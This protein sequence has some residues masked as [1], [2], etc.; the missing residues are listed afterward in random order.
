M[1]CRT[2]TRY[3]LMCALW[4][5]VSFG[6]AAQSAP[7]LTPPDFTRGERVTGENNTWALGP[8]GA[9][10]EIWAMKNAWNTVGATQI[11]VTQVDADTP[12][13]GVLSVGDV[14]L[15][16]VSPAV[17]D[18][19][20][21]AAARFVVDARK[22]LAAAITAAE[23]AKRAGRLV[24]N[25]WRDG[26]TRKAEL[27][28]RVMGSFSEASPWECEKSE[29]I[30]KRACDF[31]VKQGFEGRGGIPT[32]LDALGLLATGDTQYLPLVKQYAR[33]IGSP[34]VSLD[35]NQ[36]MV[37]WNW[38][39]TLLFLSEY[40]GVTQDDYVLPA[41]REYAITIAKGQSGAGTWGHS[42]AR[43]VENDGKLHGPCGGYGSMNQIG[44][45]C[46]LALVLAQKCGVDHPEIDQALKRSTDFMRFYVD[47][48]SLPY[49]DTDPWGE[50]D[51]NG[52]NSQ[53]AV[54][55]DLMGDGEAARYFAKMTLASYGIRERGHT[56]H[57]FSF[58][59]GAPGAARAGN[60]AAA[61]F[62]REMRWFYELERRPAGNFRYQR[63]L[64]NA[65]HDKYVNWST[66]GSR[67]MHY[68]L[69]R[70]VLYITGKGERA[71]QEIRGDELHAA[72]EA[73][74]PD[75]L[76]DRSA[77][78]LLQLLGSW[79]PTIRDR[80]GKALAESDE[81]VVGDLIAMLTSENRY[82]RY[83]A[84]KGLRYAGRGSAEAV[85]ALV[86]HGL[87]S[88]DL[89]MRFFALDALRYPP[90]RKDPNPEKGLRAVAHRAVPQLIEM[91][92]AD[93]PDEPRE[94][95]RTWVC[96]TLC[97]EGGIFKAKPEAFTGLDAATRA[98]VVRSLLQVQ[99]GRARGAV[100]T[101]YPLLTDEDL[102]ALWGPIYQA[103]Q[104][105]APSGTMFADG[106][107]AKGIAL[108]AE[109]GVEEGIALALSILNENRWGQ[110][111]R[112]LQ[113]IPALKPY[114]GAVRAHLP[115][116]KKIAGD[117][118][119]KR[120]N[121]KAALEAIETQEAPALI[122]IQAHLE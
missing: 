101:L 54:L 92:V 51:D 114:A 113:I 55:F 98:Q 30:I 47:K 37:S 49:G 15:G 87:R 57:F 28:L 99:E 69:P 39:Y 108:M 94:W 110:K 78:E 6:Y 12:A 38:A 4:M 25:V 36:T 63:Q 97:S 100:A 24:L 34:D 93:Y 61:A 42:M 79:S 53:A 66:T 106:I 58:Q 88:D 33:R 116:L 41:I 122:S 119:Q 35:I 96:N 107:R 68:C 60:D 22:E 2:M 18:H 91:A 11:Y 43:P 20:E 52:K 45:T 16:V 82:A 59:W 7:Q 29:A 3:L 17:D 50:L 67:L 115:E 9:Y 72:V 14:I 56:G 13:A 74:R 19:K 75:Y 83:G 85:D 109:H 21:G 31:L 62:M 48:G 84:C 1:T 102:K 117:W 70:K 80:A 27:T 8:T 5:G 105:R 46:T 95:T 120:G 86:A 77:R 111:T 73:G 90:R 32:H 104:E 26:V 23:E 10:G 40:Y 81:N 65:D 118:T 112:I 64:A 71:T 121:V 103:T 76:K 89:T 44:L